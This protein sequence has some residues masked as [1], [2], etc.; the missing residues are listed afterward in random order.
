[1]GKI[2]QF[3]NRGDG[4][5]GESELSRGDRRQ[6]LR[7]ARQRCHSSRPEFAWDLAHV[8]DAPGLSGEAIQAMEDG[9]AP[10]SLR[11]CQA[12]AELAG[13]TIGSLLQSVKP[14]NGAF[15]RQDHDSIAPRAG[16]RSVLRSGALLGLAGVRAV[17]DSDRLSHALVHPGRMD[18][19]CLRQLERTT[20]FLQ[21]LEGESRRDA[22]IG[23]V[24]GH[25]SHL[26]TL[27]QG[28]VSPELRCRVC[29]LAG[30]TMGL[31][32]WLSWQ[33]D[34]AEEASTWFQSGID[35]ASEADD[36]PL[37][38][39]LVGCLAT[40]PR[41]RET[42][43]LRLERL[44][45]Q[46]RFQ[47]TWAAPPTRAWL[48]TMEGEAHALMGEDGAALEA[49]D[50]ARQIVVAEGVTSGGSRP[51]VTSSFGAF[52]NADYLTAEEAVV[53]ASLGHHAEVVA[54]LEPLLGSVEPDRRKNWFWLYPALASSHIELGNVESACRLA[55]ETVRGATTMQVATNLPLVRRVRREL[56]PF[57]T[58]PEVAQLD[59]A[60][61]AAQE[62]V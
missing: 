29:S 4:R 46:G 14:G 19:E 43:R 40:Q 5:R 57:N 15:H 21:K 31:A 7:A 30:E 33:A 1:M 61:V 36:R 18:E 20:V 34:D 52:F 8:L 42:P 47:Q 26:L 22:L 35:A 25:L 45:S 41:Y 12:A 55:L 27:L 2:V 13:A 24:R 32:G 3:P 38:A 37:G 44:T 49:M 6:V 62:A 48:T 51:P 56:E 10:V 16:R 53:R 39:Y 11:T 23:P 28:S 54:I 50:R 58:Q 9:L 17:L 60:L 59:E